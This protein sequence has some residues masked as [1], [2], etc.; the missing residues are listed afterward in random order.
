[1]CW[2]RWSNIC[3]EKS[4][5][6]PLRDDDINDFVIPLNVIKQ[7]CR[8]IV[9]ED[10]HCSEASSSDST[11]EFHRQVRITNRTLRALFRH[12]DL[13]NV[14]KYPLFGFELISHKLIRLS[15]PFFM[16][17]LIPLNL[18]LAGEGLVYNLILSAQLVFYC[19]ALIGL[20][21]EYTARNKS[22]LSFVY[23]FVMVQVAIFIGWC[24][25]LSGKNQVTWNA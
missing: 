17:I 5:Y 14:F 22:K 23:H 12:A 15:V 9:G 6:K 24:K 13:M 21:E 3:N 16:L 7:G 10:I 19:L 11:K 18:I 20:Y 4:L 2:C 8:V 1:M 25:Y